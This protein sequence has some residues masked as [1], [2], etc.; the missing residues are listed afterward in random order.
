MVGDKSRTATRIDAPVPTCGFIAVKKALQ[1]QM[2][3]ICCALEVFLSRSW[4]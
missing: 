3:L 2:L 4:C 1:W